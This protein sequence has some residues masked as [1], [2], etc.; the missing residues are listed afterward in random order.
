MSMSVLH[1]FY[2]VSI[3][4]CDLK[5]TVYVFDLAHSAALAIRE[6]ALEKAM[7]KYNG[8]RVFVWLNKFVCVCVC[9]CVCACVFFLSHTMFLSPSLQL[10]TRSSGN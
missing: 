9:V 2:V 1:V 10:S 8:I 3:S 6:A 4:G 5:H 7:A